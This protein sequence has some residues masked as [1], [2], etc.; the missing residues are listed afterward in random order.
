LECTVSGELTQILE[1]EEVVSWEKSEA[2]S[3]LHS[4]EKQ[5]A[6]KG[7]AQNER[8]LSATMVFVF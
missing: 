5:Y 6:L 7:K 2:L 8:Y 1:A 4:W 3:T